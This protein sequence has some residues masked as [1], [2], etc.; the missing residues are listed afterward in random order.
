MNTI[1]YSIFAATLL[2]VLAVSTG[3]ASTTSTAKTYA[4]GCHVITTVYVG[5][6]TTCGHWTV[7][8]TDL[9]QPNANGI[10]KA[11]VNLYYNNVLTNITSIAPKHTGAYNVSGH[12]LKVDVKQTFAGLYAYQKWAKIELFR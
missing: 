3:A 12:V 4:S 10:S 6:N 8:L 7:Q 11:S 1:K 5:H 9:G 2:V